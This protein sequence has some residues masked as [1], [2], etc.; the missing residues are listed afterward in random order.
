MVTALVESADMRRSVAAFLLLVACSSP[1]P[2]P[3]ASESVAALQDSPEP[4]PSMLPALAWNSDRATQDWP[5]PLRVVA[6][7]A[8]IVVPTYSDDPPG[9][10]APEFA[11]VDIVEVVSRDCGWFPPSACVFFEMGAEVPRPMPDPG[12]QWIGYGIV[13]DTT[14]DGHPDWRFGIDNAALDVDYGRMWRTDLAT[15]STFSPSGVLEA[16]TVMDAVFPGD[17][18]PPPPGDGGSYPNVRTGSIFAK[19]PL[20]DEGVFHFYVWAS[21]I[22][23]GQIVATDYAPDAGWFENPR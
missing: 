23:D 21:V 12:S 8:P 22:F 9:D 3:S 13:V 18:G 14:G 4:S 5:G 15:G 7:G 2:T 19:E 11:V 6:P 20:P 16:P 17:W 10:V 1:S